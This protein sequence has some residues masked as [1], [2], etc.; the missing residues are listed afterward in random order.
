MEPHL[1]LFPSRLPSECLG[2]S[3]GPKGVSP[4]FPGRWSGSRGRFGTVVGPVEEGT[5]PL[6]SEGDGEGIES[7]DLSGLNLGCKGRG[8]ESG[9]CENSEGCE[10]C[11]EYGEPHLDYDGGLSGLKYV[12]GMLT[13]WRSTPS[14]YLVKIAP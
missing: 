3:V 13:D 2:V 4:F 6:G 11:E 7:D 9:R 1:E 5:V 12:G 10:G 14:L 8:G